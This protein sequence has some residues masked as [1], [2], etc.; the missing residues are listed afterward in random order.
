LPKYEKVLKERLDTLYSKY[1]HKKFIK[2]D[3]IKYVY[4]FEDDTERELVGLI[5]SSFSF[6]RV[7]QIFK[8]VDRFLDMVNNQPLM[9]VSNLN[10]KPDERLLSFKHRFV[11]GQDVF[12]LLLS[13]KKIIEGYGSIGK[14][15]RKHYRRGNFLELAN[16]TIK[17]FQGVNYLI[18]S[19][20]R[21]SPC[22]RLF[23][24]F[25]WMVRDDR[26]DLGLWKFISPAELVIP[27]DTHIFRV[28]KEL[29]F[30]SKRTAS[31]GTALE[32]TENLRTYSENDPVKYDWAL[33]R[34]GIIRNNF[35]L[36]E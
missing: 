7:K 13:A 2:F 21:N 25:R 32:I 28:S 6:G 9:Y 14:F 1:N 35:M 30:T 29:G 22:K 24:F 15:A 16:E 10:E 36:Q 23:M 33:S 31:L 3:P 17:A 5:C 12:D 19:T 11:T 20:L 27:L 8:A 4:A 18:P 34:A 26:I